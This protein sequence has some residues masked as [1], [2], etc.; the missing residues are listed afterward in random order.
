[1]PTENDKREHE[2]KQFFAETMLEFSSGKY[3]ARISDIS[4]GGCYVDSIASV[5]EGEVISL[6]LELGDGV[7]HRFSGV[8]AYVLP[9]FGFGVRFTDLTEEKTDLL[10][11]LIG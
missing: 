7:P 10:H 3:E 4:L 8:V 6:S 2:R 9:G 5:V 1:M 11:R